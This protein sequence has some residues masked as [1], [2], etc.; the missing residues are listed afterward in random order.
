MGGTIIILQ[1]FLPYKMKAHNNIVSTDSSLQGSTTPSPCAATS[2]QPI[3]HNL[4][5]LF[6][7]VVQ[8]H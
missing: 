7:F 5:S 3:R 6:L 2:Q 4:V 1:F 8:G